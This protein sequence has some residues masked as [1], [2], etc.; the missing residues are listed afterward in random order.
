MSAQAGKPSGPAMRIFPAGGSSLKNSLNTSTD[1]KTASS[2]Q[3]PVA[4]KISMS[5]CGYAPLVF[6]E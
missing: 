4:L 5:F 2:G 6:A 3:V 1:I